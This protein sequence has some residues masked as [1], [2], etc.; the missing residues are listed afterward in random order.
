LLHS[1]IFIRYRVNFGGGAPEQSITAGVET[2]VAPLWSA[3]QTQRNA[4]LSALDLSDLPEVTLTAGTVFQTDAFRG[5][6]DREAG[7]LLGLRDEWSWREPGDRTGSVGARM[8]SEG[9]FSAIPTLAIATDAK[10]AGIL[11]L[12]RNAFSLRAGAYVPLTLT[13]RRW[14][15]STYRIFASPIGFVQY[16]FLLGGD[17]ASGVSAGFGEGFSAARTLTDPRFCSYS[18]GLRIGVFGARTFASARLAHHPTE[19]LGYF[20][21]TVGKFGNFESIAAASP[22]GVPIPLADAQPGSPLARMRQPRIQ[23][24]L[25]APV[26]RSFFFI[27]GEINTAIPGTAIPP[28]YT[29]PPNGVTFAIGASFDAWRLSHRGD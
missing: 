24:A 9:R 20:D 26:P 17:P 28:A 3:L 25:Q 10:Q 4:L 7:L 11:M 8:F 21:V 29:R 16:S 15:T 13:R 23:F 18:S 1:P 27:R 22:T 19:T 6:R 5:A 2:D 14:S 12:A